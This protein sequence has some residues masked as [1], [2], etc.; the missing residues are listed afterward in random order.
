MS[1]LPFN[2]QKV[3]FGLMIQLTA[4]LT[5]TTI[6]LQNIIAQQLLAE[7]LVHLI[8]DMLMQGEH[9]ELGFVLRGPSK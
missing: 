4:V 6:T 8:R 5:Q 1:L 3:V 7:K 2:T 9:L